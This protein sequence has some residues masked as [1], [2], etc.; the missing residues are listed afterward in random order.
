M[1]D[2]KSKLDAL[3]GESS[4]E[5]DQ[6]EM[7]VVD[8]KPNISALLGESSDEE[9]QVESG[10]IEEEK[11]PK[12]NPKSE[13]NE[14]DSDDSAND[15]QNKSV[16]SPSKIDDNSKKATTTDSQNEETDKANELDQI[17]GEQ[18]IKAEVKQEI[19]DRTQS[20]LQLPQSYRVSSNE[21]SYFV[22]TPNFVKIQPLPFNADSHKQD[23]E[24]DLYDGVTSIMRHRDSRT[25]P[26]TLESNTRLVKWDDGTYQLVVG[27][28]I[29]NAKLVP[30]ENI[31]IFEQQKATVTQKAEGLEEEEEE[32]TRKT[33]C[34]ECIG[35]TEGKMILQPSSLNSEI[36]ARMSL[37]IQEKFKKANNIVIQDYTE[38][39]E[40]PEVTLAALARKEEDMIRKERKARDSAASGVSS[41]GQNSYSQANRRP[42][43]SADYLNENDEFDMDH[44]LPIYKARKPAKKKA[45]RS[46]G[47]EEE[48]EGEYDDDDEEEDGDD[49]EDEVERIRK[50]QLSKDKKNNKKK[51]DK[52]KKRKLDSTAEKPSKRE[53]YED[54]GHDDDDD[55]VEYDDEDDDEDEGQEGSQD[56]A[57]EPNTQE[58]ANEDDDADDEDMMVRKA[59]SKKTKRRAIIDSDDDEDDD[60]GADET[61]QSGGGAEEGG[62]GNDAIDGTVAVGEQSG[63]E[64]DHN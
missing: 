27:K 5:E 33:S 47:E 43:M 11:K 6:G 42:S 52:N 50:E 58:M 20:K 17:L 4:D 37:K 49:H 10:A 8:D 59:A 18:P 14:F 60:E 45:K 28:A 35:N 21:K 15:P 46:R 53:N 7:K 26:G 63:P 57:E 13:T 12:E 44:S 51:K 40:K 24:R 25:N 62:E 41:Y 16:L 56:E 54:D 31:F 23:I 19:K 34:W 38:L 2:D 9:D 61:G 30:T 55:E 29:F 1:D 48:E 39:T 36:H 32:I 64:K 3:L 22:R